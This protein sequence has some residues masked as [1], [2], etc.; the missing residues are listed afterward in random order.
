MGELRSK[1]GGY[2]LLDAKVGNV[3]IQKAFMQSD[4]PLEEVKQ[5]Q[6]TDDFYLHIPD[7]P[8]TITEE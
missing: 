2:Y 1:S 4:K 6:Q 5:L 7:Q 8:I 3:E